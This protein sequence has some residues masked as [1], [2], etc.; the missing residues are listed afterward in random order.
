ML[1][2]CF[3]MSPHRQIGRHAV[4]FFAAVLGLVTV[5]KAR[6]GD[7]RSGFEQR[8]QQSTRTPILVLNGVGV[9][10]FAIFDLYAVGLYLERKTRSAA[11]AVDSKGHK[12]VLIQ[13]LRDTRADQ[14]ID[15]LREGIAFTSTE[16]QRARIAGRL[17]I[18]SAPYR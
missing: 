16:D 5:E 4:L 17:T 15:A 10:R 18:A 11:E 7:N 13:L 1:S 2:V 14:V 6:A 8:V 12:R 3:A 9:K